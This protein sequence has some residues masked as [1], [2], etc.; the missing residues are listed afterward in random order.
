MQSSM[1]MVQR[2]REL[3]VQSHNGAYTDK[4]RLNLQLQANTLLVQLQK[5]A[6]TSK[7]NEINL[8]DGIYKS[9]IRVKAN[10]NHRL[11]WGLLE[12]M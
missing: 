11:I 12:V 3:A 7:F 5:N 10:D 9:Y 4:D 6:D 2:L 1:E 8:L